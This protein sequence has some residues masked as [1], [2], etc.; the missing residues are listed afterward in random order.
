NISGGTF[1]INTASS[2]TTPVN[3]TNGTLKVTAAGGSANLTVPTL[4]VGGA[5]NVIQVVNAP[6]INTYPSAFPIIKYTTLTGIP[7]VSGIAPTFSASLPTSGFPP[8]GGFISNDTATTTLYLVFTNGPVTP[9]L[10]W[11]GLSGSGVLNSAWDFVANDWTNK[12]AHTQASYTDGSLVVFDDGGV[13]NKVDL[14]ASDVYPA[15]VTFSN[16][17]VSYTLRGSFGIRTNSL[18]KQGSGKVILDN[19][20]GSTNDYAGGTTISGGILQVGVNDAGGGLGSGAVANNGTLVFN[21]NNS[22]LTIPNAISGSGG[23]LLSNAAGNTTIL[24]G[25]N[26]TY[27]GS[28]YVT[29]GMTLAPANANALS[30]TNGALTIPV[31]AT[32]DVSG[33]GIGANTLVVGKSVTVSGAGVDNIS[34]AIVNPVNTNQQNAL[35]HVTLAADT[36]VGGAGRFDIR[37]TGASLSTGGSAYNLTKKGA[38]QFSIVGATVDPALNNVDVQG[39]TLSV[40]TSTTGLGNTSANLTMENGTTLQLFN[41]AAKLNKQISM[42]TSISDSTTVNGANG[43]STIIGPMSM[44]GF[45]TLN[46]ANGAT[47]TLS[48]AI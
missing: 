40:E 28:V 17:A 41:L 12:P 20:L 47:L 4:N 8:F 13:T 1:F 18:T 23:I 5:A 46:T 9:L 16:N 44:N 11:V 3:F 19:A 14:N 48:N 10:T 30:S 45:V 42:G 24:S 32:L 39:G 37:G 26:A 21:R 43:Q 15:G 29:N 6:L 7:N 22:V 35:L 2:G 25:N 38:G 31:G 27:S 33:Q 34:G 36:T